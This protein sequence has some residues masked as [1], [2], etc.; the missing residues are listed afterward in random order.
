MIEPGKFH[1]PEDNRP[2]VFYFTSWR[3]IKKFQINFGSLEGNYYVEIKFFDLE[4]FQGKTIQ[5]IKT[6]D[7]P[8]Q[9]L[10]RF[11]NTNLYRISIYLEK[12]SDVST[13]KNPYLFS[14]LPFS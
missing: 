11:K 7:F 8:S 5:E 12:R 13:D 2:Y 14:I 3:K 9:H 6:L 10:Y 1:L 4:L